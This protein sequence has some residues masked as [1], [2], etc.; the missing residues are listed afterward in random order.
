MAWGSSVIKKYI[1]GR[2]RV[3][4][5]SFD[6]SGA[7]GGD[8]A[9]GLKRVEGFQLTHKGTA[10]AANVAVV[11]ETFPLAGGDVTLVC[12]SGDTGYWIAVGI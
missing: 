12:T 3:H 7:T 8:V 4:C 11:N 2:S 9:T 1:F 10:V 6:S 5:G